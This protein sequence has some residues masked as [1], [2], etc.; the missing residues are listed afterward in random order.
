MY[1]CILFLLRLLLFITITLSTI[2]VSTI[3]ESARKDNNVILIHCMA[4]ISRSVTLTIAYI[5]AFFNL[6]MQDAYQYVKDKR[7]AI[8]P[9]LNFMGQLVEF[10]RYCNE[11][12][13]RDKRDMTEYTPTQLQQDTSKKLMQKI[14]RSGSTAS[15]TGKI[16]HIFETVKSI[17]KSESDGVTT[18]APNNKPFVLKPLNTKTRR[19]KKCKDNVD[20]LPLHPSENNKPPEVEENSNDVINNPTTATNTGLVDPIDTSE[21]V[22]PGPGSNEDSLSRPSRPKSPRQLVVI[23]I[24]GEKMNLQHRADGRSATPSP[25]RVTSPNNVSN[26]K[27]QS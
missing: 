22:L 26:S 13:P 4:G 9:N 16:H 23:S 2:Y 11:H 5:M 19:P 8:S 15:L 10:E 27:G 20:D 3:L 1:M 24:K 17:E 14:A 7:P 21:L 6:S 12:G 18:I 25:D